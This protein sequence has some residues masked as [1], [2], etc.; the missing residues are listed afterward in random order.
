MPRPG[1]SCRS[2]II[3]ELQSSYMKTSQSILVDSTEL[4]SLALEAVDA[5][6]LSYT[7]IAREL[8]MA[9]PTISGAMNPNSGG[10]YNATRMKIVSRWHPRY[11]I[12]GEMHLYV[13]VRRTPPK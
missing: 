3:G 12:T 9:Q 10:R 13:A 8:G 7:E 5:C 4:Y 6:G 11:T 1:V 2:N